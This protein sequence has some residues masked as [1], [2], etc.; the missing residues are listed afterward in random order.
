[1]KA[2]TKKRQ[3]DAIDNDES[4]EPKSAK[5]SRIVKSKAIKKK[6]KNVAKRRGSKFNGKPQVVDEGK[7]LD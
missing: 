4:Y 7:K 6:T 2:N 1:M 5:N 3:Q